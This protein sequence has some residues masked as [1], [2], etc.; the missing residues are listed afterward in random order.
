MLTNSKVV[1]MTMVVE[2]GRALVVATTPLSSA[3]R[4]KG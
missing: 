2:M 4:I 1:V 3:P